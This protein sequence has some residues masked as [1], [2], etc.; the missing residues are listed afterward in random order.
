MPL[1]VTDEELLNAG[2]PVK[3][4]VGAM[5]EVVVG[6]AVVV[7]KVVDEVTLTGGTVPTVV[8]LSSPPQLAKTRAALS[9]RVTC[10]CV[11]RREVPMAKV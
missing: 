8:S 6:A 1:V 9:A 3:S 4:R 7:V 10:R 11:S 5:L 2:L